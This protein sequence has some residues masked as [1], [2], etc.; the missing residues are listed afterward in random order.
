[1]SKVW[2]T[3]LLLA[4]AF[5]VAGGQWLLLQSVAW[6]NM[7]RDY[8]QNQTLCQALTKTFD[9]N[10]PCPLCRFIQKEKTAQS[11]PKTLISIQK[12]PF[13]T[14][15]FGI[16]LVIFLCHSI[17]PRIQSTLASLFSPP[18]YPPPKPFT[19]FAAN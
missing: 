9:G 10:H 16:L 6:V 17:T 18:P 19:L 4:L 13:L 15:P 8:S 3:S 5:W 12:N 2:K 1:M 14:V 11:S 7:V